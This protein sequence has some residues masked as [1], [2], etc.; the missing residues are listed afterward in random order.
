MTTHVRPQIS[1]LAA[2]LLG[3][4]APPLSMGGCTDAPLVRNV[5]I[6]TPVFDNKLALSGEVCTSDPSDL[7]FPLKVMFII[8]TSQSMNINDPAD[9]AEMDTTKATNRARAIRDVV[10][11]FI[12]LSMEFTTT[13]G[14]PAYCNTGENGCEQGSD[15]CA[16]CNT[17]YSPKQALCVGWDCCR[18]PP[19]R[20]VP[21]CP[22]PPDTNG[23]CVP[24]C[25]AT[26]A[27]LRPG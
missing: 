16:A 2:L 19:C 3:A 6:V 13:T 22:V 15:A 20:G 24:L 9:P 11:Q 18:T 12:D 25:D 14:A 17:A 21:A 4:V 1:L 10:T 27:E 23:T 7:T 8:D 5:E 26:K